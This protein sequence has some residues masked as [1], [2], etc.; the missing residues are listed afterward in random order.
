[1]SRYPKGVTHR[2]DGNGLDVCQQCASE[3]TLAEYRER[4]DVVLQSFC[5]ACAMKVFQTSTKFRKYAERKRVK[6]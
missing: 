3:E 5:S 4:E 1:M 6:A 2:R